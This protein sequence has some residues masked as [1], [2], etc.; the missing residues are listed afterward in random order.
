MIESVTTLA[1]AVYVGIALVSFFGS[2]TRDLV[3][4]LVAGV[5][6]GVQQS[7]GKIVINFG[8][9][10]LNIGDALGA[11]LNLAVALIVVSMTL[12]YIRA[13]SPLKGGR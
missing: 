3:T 4:P 9:I 7:L 13:Y 1:V 5:F 8:G 6:P 2:I 11:T 10:Q 12:P